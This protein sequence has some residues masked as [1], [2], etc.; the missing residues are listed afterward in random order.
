MCLNFKLQT[1]QRRYFLIF[2]KKYNKINKDAMNDHKTHTSLSYM[3]KFIKHQNHNKY[4]V[5]K[6]IHKTFLK[7]NSLQLKN[8]LLEAIT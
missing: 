1:M 5:K 8:H 4:Y 3:Y 6:Y 7:L 2:Q